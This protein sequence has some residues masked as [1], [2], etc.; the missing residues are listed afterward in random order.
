MSFKLPELLS[1]AGDEESIHA[2]LENGAD[3][4]YFGISIHGKYNAR[5]RARNIPIENLKSIMQLLH[6]RSMSGYVTLNT[7]V[8]DCEL[9]EIEQLIREIVEAGVD[10]IIVQDIGVA[11]FSKQFC[12]SLPIHAST[13]MSLTSPDSIRFMSSLGL[14][15]IVLPRE[16]S[17]Q[18]IR[19]IR[20]STNL[21][22]EAFI[23][24]SLCISFS[25][26]CYASLAIGGRSANRGCCA[27]PCR[28]PYSLIDNNRVNN[29]SQLLSPCDLAALPL[30][31]ELISTGIN[32]LKIEGRLK[33][34]EYVAEVT[35]TYREALGKIEQKIIGSG[36]G[37]GSGSDS[38][39]NSDS[40]S[41]LKLNSQKNDK[42]A[43]T[44]SAD[45]SRLELIFSRGLSTGWLDKVEPRNLVSGNIMSHRGIKIGKVIEVRRDA[46][47]VLLSDRIH[48]G[49]GVLFENS[50][51][52]DCSQGGRVYEIIRKGESVQECSENIKVLLTFANNSIEPQYVKSGQA[53]RKTNDPKVEREIRRSFESQTTQRRIPVNISITAIAGTPLKLYAETSTGAKCEIIC[54]DN[55]DIAV[56]HPITLEMLRTQFNRFGDTIFSLGNL[57]AIIDGNPMIP[58]SKLGKLRH[59]LID[60]LESYSPQPKT[61]I[62]FH[63]N[64]ETIQRNIHNLFS[65]ISVTKNQTADINKKTDLITIH[66]LLREVEIFKDIKLLKR[67]ISLGCNSFYAEF[68]NIE[69]YQFAADAVRRV[70]GKFAAVLPRIILPNENWKSNKFIE[71]KPDVVIIRNYE[72]LLFFKENNIPVIADFSFNVINEL[73]FHKLLEWGVER[74]TPGFDLNQE[75]LESLCDKVPKS[76]VELIVF[77]RVPL[78]TMNHCLWRA[79]IIPPNQPCKRICK[80]VPL[81]IKDRC[82]AI[83]SVRSDILCK[84]IIENA[85]EYSIKPIKGIRNLRIE[86]DSRLG[87]LIEILEKINLQTW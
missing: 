66:L 22:I 28:I 8:H 79:N 42:F 5:V 43:D 72:E 56:K 26:Q 55:L 71:L 51:Q 40:C 2:A 52:P 32:S 30:L 38:D 62:E 16:L 82:G 11:V 58:L 15:R 18:Q 57:D 35:R 44:I 36:S 70:S 25:G 9:A 80:Q 4:V 54:N 7:L 50:G 29:P 37:S 47:V 27:Q 77:G 12:P 34:A 53:V 84:N 74:I 64:I 78:F 13:Q 68:G 21:E 67:I 24:G 1:P 45:T 69:E 33:P 85:A 76:K 48:R 63:N 83:H 49:D 17:L 81:K 39:S 3:A 19:S 31:E 10:A 41:K 75:Q 87:N 20:R 86:W 73:S 6:N 14:S 23:H 65:E 61:K 59:D 46:V 60:K